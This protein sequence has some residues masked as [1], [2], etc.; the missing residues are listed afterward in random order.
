MNMDAL[1]IFTCAFFIVLWTI[2][3]ILPI[4]KARH[5]YDDPQ[6]PL[7]IHSRPTPR[8][9]GVAIFLGFTLSLL[10]WSFGNPVPLVGHLLSA[11]LLLFALGVTDDLKGAG[12]CTKLIMEC[13]AALMITMAGDVRLDSLYGL[14]N[15]YELSYCGSIILSVLIL[16]FITNAFNLIDGIDGLAAAT[17]ILIHLIFAALFIYLQQQVLAAVALSMA[18][19]ALGFLKYNLTPARIFMGDTGSLL[20]GLVSA[21][22]ALKFIEVNT[23]PGLKHAMGAASTLA[24]TGTIL[25]IPVADT[26][27]VLITRIAK[28][29]SPFTGDLNHI[30]HRMLRFGFTHLQTTAILVL[31]NIML[32][33]M[34]L[35]LCC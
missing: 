6:H 28:G 25:I 27:S 4:A 26:I 8:L 19:A 18:G 17:G 30:H 35:M 10:I 5:W 14:F 22:M 9:G 13:V 29:K 2:P 15:V 32:V 3:A 21:V 20:I 11:C 31:L 34:V 33:S 12:L 7:K 16:V 23:T 1:L 24:V